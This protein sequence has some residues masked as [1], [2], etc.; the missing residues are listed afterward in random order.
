MDLSS[1]AQNINY[2]YTSSQPLFQFGGVASGLDTASI[3]DKLME[4][5][6]QPLNRLNEKYTELD[7]Q[8]K[9]Y[10]A[11][12]D[13]LREFMDYLSD[14]RLQSSLLPKGATSTNENVL[15][16]T[17]AAS[18]PDGTYTVNVVQLASR[19][20]Y[21]GTKLGPDI[22]TT[23]AFSDI[24][25]N[26]TPQDSSL[27]LTVN[28]N[29]ASINILTTDTINDIITKIQNAFTTAGSSA[30]VTYD[31]TNNKLS[32]QSSDVFQLTQDSGNFLEVFRLDNANL[33]SSGGNY[34]LTS[35]GDIGV[36]STSKLLSDLGVTGTNSF[37]INGTT[38]SY[39]DTDTI[40]DFISNI[41]S[42]V[43]GVTAS[44]DDINNQILI[45]ADDTG[46][47][48]INI[49]G[50]PAELGLSSGQFILGNVAYAQITM[51][52]GV[53]YDVY[54]DTNTLSFQGMQID[55]VSTGTAN[56]TV[57]TDIDAIVDKVSEFVEKWNDTM[58]YLYTKL[59]ENEVKDKSEDEMTEEEKIQG[60]LKN[61][62][63]LRKIFDK[64]RSYLYEE[65]N[66]TYLW[67]LGISSGDSGG[68]YENTM[69]GKIELDEDKL[70][71]Y[72][73]N[74]GASAVWEFFG[75]DTTSVQGFATQLKDYL[76]DLTKF[77]GEIDQVAGVSGRIE[78]E[79]RSL[80]KQIVN[81]IEILEKKQQDLWQKFSA[82]EQ[83]LSR[84]NMQGAYLSQ[85][86][87]SGK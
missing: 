5:E 23:T 41:N 31:D 69:K 40:A 45:T 14:F 35:T 18:T 29:T 61:D 53:T 64:I 34:T 85:A 16:A 51:D 82:M 12:S 10:N 2:R 44:Y 8:Q 77:N 21:M 63:Y 87:S 36:Y 11:V 15:T 30:T 74:N 19:S 46:D 70:R 84:L 78:R 38:I 80:A 56:I 81:W 33:V 43:S 37:T 25:H 6:S 66:G 55:V 27:T 52:N 71:D 22:T 59:T 13:K 62:S 4:I 24:N 60:V 20:Y 17:A 79:K 73:S 48:I 57:S 68:S 76:Y 75:S 86:F 28:G 9:A 32:I 3:I 72:I 39:S 67:E 1:I 58:D 50:G 83:A 47:V 7:R 49:S 26:Y 54:S 65:V 42:N